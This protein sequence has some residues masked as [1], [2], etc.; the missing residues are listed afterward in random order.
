MRSQLLRR[1]CQ[2]SIG[3][4]LCLALPLLTACGDVSTK[5]P[6][7]LSSSA[8]SANSSQSS[9]SLAISP[10]NA[11]VTQGDSLN[12]SATVPGS[13]N[14]SVNWS[15][16][17]GAAG[18]SITN[19]GVYT[20][21][22]AS[23][24]K[25]HVVAT[26]VAN[27]TV[28]AVASVDVQPRGTTAKGA[29]IFTAVGNMATQRANH[30]ATLLGNGK[31][32]IA[33]GWDGLE[34]LASAELY[35]PATRTF[36]P[37]GSMIT[38]RY[39]HLAV[40]LAD[41]QVLI[42]GGR[43]GD[44]DSAA[45]YALFSAEIYDPSTG[46]FTRTGDMSPLSGNLPIFLSRNVSALL[47]DGRVFVVG[48]KNAETYDPKSG[49]FAP[50][51]PYVQLDGWFTATAT[52]LLNGKVL[53]SGSDQG[54]AELFDPQNG[55]FSMTGPMTYKYF[56]DYGYA[57]T[58]LADGRVLFVGTDEFAG[59]NAEIYDP[60][61][62]TFVSGGNGLW[63]EDLFPAAARL[64]DGRVLFAGGQ[65]FGGDGSASTR[66]YVPASG[67][68]EFGGSM[69]LGRHS[70]TVTALADDTALVT[71]GYSLWTW[72]H[73]QPTATAEVYKPQ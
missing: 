70:Q 28:T 43:S 20:A 61:T 22:A 9:P 51:D 18:G 49:T 16:Q 53:V 4:A 71:G 8:S 13:A 17:E 14:A 21:P 63:A 56:P 69:T 73:P 3:I 36:T 67:T 40:L 60:A 24:G 45:N 32:L 72:P 7:S 25:F 27:A 46:V 6:S 31:V 44:Q 64:S 65:L 39:N 12:F 47:P 19:A 2:P 68:F 29:G 38:A 57:A 50:T 15:I 62:G 26:S 55:T 54:V 35:D 33:G 37:T 1:P 5:L 34:P 58:L 41:G 42:A 23:I 52:L 30:T 10:S 66:L 48:T 59:A 11:M